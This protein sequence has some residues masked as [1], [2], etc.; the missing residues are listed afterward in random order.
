MLKNDTFKKFSVD[1]CVV[2]S[3]K[4]FTLILVTASLSFN[5]DVRLTRRS[6]RLLNAFA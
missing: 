5:L 3:K 1:T 6:D 2:I 4:L